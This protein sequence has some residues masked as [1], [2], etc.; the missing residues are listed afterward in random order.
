VPTPAG[1]ANSSES[2]RWLAQATGLSEDARNY[3][4]F[5]GL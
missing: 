1:S 2:M 4:G 3:S 5:Q